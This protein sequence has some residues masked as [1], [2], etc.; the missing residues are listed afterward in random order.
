MSDANLRALRTEM[1]Q[2]QR[3]VRAHERREAATLHS[4]GVVL[5]M[6]AVLVF[7]LSGSAGLACTWV[8]RRQHERFMS[9]LVPPVQVTTPMLETWREQWGSHGALA[10]PLCSLEH[11]WRMEVDRFLMES[12]VVERIAAM[13]AS[14]VSVPPDQV[15]EMTVRMWM[16]RPRTAQDDRWLQKLGSDRKARAMH[17]WHFRRRWGLRSGL[18]PRRDGLSQDMFLQRVASIKIIFKLDI[19][20]FWFII[21]SVIGCYFWF[22]LRKKKE[23]GLAH[24]TKPTQCIYSCEVLI[25]L[26]WT[27]WLLRHALRNHD[28]VV[29]N[30]DETL[31]SNQTQ[32]RHGCY[33]HRQL[34]DQVTPNA[35]PR[36]S[37]EPR[38]TLIAAI[39][40]RAELQHLLPQVTLQ[41]GG[42]TVTEATL[43]SNAAG[44][45]ESLPRWCNSTGMMDA[46]FLRRWVMALRRALFLSHPSTWVVLALDCCPVHLSRH[47]LLHCTR[48]GVII[49][50]IPARTTWFLQPLDVYVF[51]VLKRRLAQRL[52]E[53]RWQETGATPSVA[54]RSAVQ[55]HV[56]RHLLRDTEWTS[57]LRRCG[58]SALAHDCRVPLQHISCGQDVKARP[59]SAEELAILCG[60]P[61]TH[62]QKM[63]KMILKWPERLRD[64][65]LPL[66]PPTWCM[67]RR[68]SEL[69]R[70]PARHQQQ[71][72]AANIAPTQDH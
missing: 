52:H 44:S 36:C 10:A 30:M 31:I 70:P 67:P 24:V 41:K 61:L 38:T 20:S 4:P 59:P 27:S 71:A 58:L 69:L 1:Q 3:R 23:G 64:C 33:V 72:S 63:H 28:V 48:L 16:H 65:S 54:D 14:G 29:V 46:S 9:T 21:L 60:R 32:W 51:A 68:A 62:A 22:Y 6:K 50:F 8:T 7:L 11:P 45:D 42:K 53:A 37:R 5:Q 57:A 19:A 26:R 39:C 18:M 34:P 25:Y 56:A 40:D 47:F 35:P 12:L 66:S 13:N 2:L 17:L 43:A 49:V 15:W 55:H